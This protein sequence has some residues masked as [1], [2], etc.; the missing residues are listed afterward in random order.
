F[1][2][3]SLD[4]LLELQPALAGGVGQGL[5]PAV[6]LEAAPVEHDGRDALLLR[7]ARDE[8]AHLLGRRDVR[9]RLRAFAQLLVQRGGRAQRLA[10]V[11]VDHLG[12][13]VALAAEHRQARALG[14]PG[15]ALADAPVDAVPDV[16]FRLD[17]HGLLGSRARRARLAGLL[18]QALA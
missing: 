12:V 6:V 18:L 3:H 7:A 10:R 13:D 2:V 8:L 11:V 15:D 9:A 16:L 14:G 1:F 5:D 17:L 4:Y